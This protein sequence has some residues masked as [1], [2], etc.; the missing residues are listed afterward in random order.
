M[1]WWTESLYRLTWNYD[2]AASKEGTWLRNAVGLDWYFT[3]ALPRT[4][5]FCRA[6]GSRAANLCRPPPGR[7]AGTQ[8]LPQLPPP[9]RSPVR[10]LCVPPARAAVQAQTEPAADCRT[11]W[12][13]GQPFPFQ[14]LVLPL[15]MVEFL[16]G[17]KSQ[18]LAQFRAWGW[19]S[20]TF[21]HICRNN[22]IFGAEIFIKK[23]SFS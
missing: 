20:I 11:C 6:P 4:G 17:E 14:V 18:S 23:E 8:V 22:V 5:L 2:S 1:G 15:A 12:T 10:S 19:V 13:H 7:G 21:P 3:G 9:Q 16:P